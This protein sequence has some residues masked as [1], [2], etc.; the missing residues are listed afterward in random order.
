MSGEMPIFERYAE[1]LAAE[2]IVAHWLVVATP[3]VF[4]CKMMKTRIFQKDC[5]EAARNFKFTFEHKSST[6][7]KLSL[8]IYSAAQNLCHLLADSAASRLFWFF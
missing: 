4:N 6:K 1:L 2:E 8:L 7:R 5:E 3:L